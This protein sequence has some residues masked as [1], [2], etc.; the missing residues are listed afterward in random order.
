MYSTERRQA[1]IVLDFG[2]QYSR[3][4]TRRVRE[5]H[6]YSELVPANTT[7]AELQ[8]K[9][10]LDIKGFILSGGPSSVYDDDAPICDPAILQSGLPIL[11]I[12]YGMHILANQL[13]GH[14]APAQ[15]R[16]EY[17]P[18]T[19]DVPPNAGDDEQAF[20]IFAGL[21]EQFGASK[22]DSLHLPV[23]MSHGDSVDQLP[24][25]FRVLACTESNPVAVIAHPQGL[26]G[27]QF[28]PEV[29]HTKQGK[30]LINNFLFRI[31]AC[32]GDW[33]SGSVIEET[34]EQIR[35]RIGSERVL[36]AL[37]GGVDSAVAALLIHR[38]VGDQLT[39][40]FVDTG[41]LRAGER[42]QVVETFSG[43]LHIPLVVVDAKR[44]FLA[45]LADVVDP[46]QKRK[47]IG[48]E[49]IRVFEE[50]AERLA[51]QKGPIAFLAQGTLYPDVIESTSHD[52]ASTAKR[53]KTHHNVG[54]LPEDIK[55]KLVEPLRTLFKDEVREIGQALGL[56]E[57]WVWRHPFPGP[58]LAIR[59]IGPVDEGRL[60]VLRAADKVVIEEIR[61]A[62]IYRELGQAFAVL[63]P[64]QSV[65]VMGDGRT[66]AN[67]VAV[68]AVTTGDFMTADWARLSP[69]LL[70]RIS[71]RLVNEVPG[72]NRVVYDITSKPPA[73]I[74]WE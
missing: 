4:I 71:H 5:S 67:V 37:S 26:I 72:V 34:V 48:E 52:T 57:E 7:L 12:C 66:Y 20:R 18:A 46:E 69:D 40:V 70:A 23:W 36:C 55:F 65:G 63:T 64:I 15:G 31:C 47:I 27:L 45:R 49:F 6:V 10:Y 25:G 30:E 35:S 21:A 24:A 33:T 22:Q 16:R 8:Q 74:E 59:V 58:G 62:G 53:I 14:V 54:G 1:I 38:A 50:E 42:E 11:G 28:H 56:P 60:D 17:G 13:G 61:K 73:T 68:R 19:I 43:H 3:L 51:E 2:S 39:C 29:T 9:P 44:R 32:A 41:C